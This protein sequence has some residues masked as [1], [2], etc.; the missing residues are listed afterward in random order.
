[1]FTYP[2]AKRQLV[3]YLQYCQ[4]WGKFP[5]IFRGIFDIFR[6]AFKS[7]CIPRVFNRVGKHLSVYAPRDGKLEVIVQKKKSLYRPRQALRVP[8]V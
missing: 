7:L 5:A 1:M 4:L 6:L 8:G 3:A 2:K